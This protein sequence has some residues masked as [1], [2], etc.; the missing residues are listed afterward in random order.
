MQCSRCLVEYKKSST[1]RQL[2]WLQLSH[3]G[4]TKD[5][6]QVGK[7]SDKDLGVPQRD[8]SCLTGALE[9]DF[10]APKDNRPPRRTDG[11][12][13]ESLHMFQDGR[14]VSGGGWGRG[15]GGD[16]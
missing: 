4:T 3:R 16:L 12:S 5:L 6:H 7:G 2:K 9:N 8:T 14:I 13:V 1:A 10:I 15:R 11:G